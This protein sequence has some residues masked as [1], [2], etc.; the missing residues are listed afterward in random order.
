[1]KKIKASLT[2]VIL[3][4]AT[5]VTQFANAYNWLHKKSLVNS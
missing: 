5:P 4:K 2:P 1:M 3:I